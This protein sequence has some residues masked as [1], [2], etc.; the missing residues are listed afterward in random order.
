[1]LSR[2]VDIPL[3]ENLRD[4]MNSD[5]ASAG[6]EDLALVFSQSVELGDLRYRPPCEL[7][8]TWRR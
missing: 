4:P 6:F 2:N 7:R 8:A 3:P 5:A 1:M